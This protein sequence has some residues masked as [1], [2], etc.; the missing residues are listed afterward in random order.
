MINVGDVLGL[1]ARNRLFLSSNKKEGRKIADSK[2]QTKRFLRKAGL[3]TPRILTI[4]R[5]STQIND[6]A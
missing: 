6:F 3:P 5:N 2:L 1:N 4:F